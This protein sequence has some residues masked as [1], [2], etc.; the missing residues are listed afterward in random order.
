MGTLVTIRAHH[1]DEALAYRAIAAAF[2]RMHALDAMLS[3]YRPDS[4][5]NQLCR[6]AHHTPFSASPDLFRVLSESLRMARATAGAFSPAIGPL[7]ELWRKA[8]QQH[9]LPSPAALRD[10]RARASWR[11]IRLDPA[12]G[13]VRLPRPGMQLDFGG[14]AKGYAADEA[15]VVLAR[16]G[17][18]RAMVAASGDIAVSVAPGASIPWHVALD[19][20][21]EADAPV[22]R[23][24]HHA[25][26]TS[27]DRHQHV[28]IEGVRYSHIV[29]P[30]TGFGLTQPIAAS[31]IGPSALHTDS[32][33]TA[34]TVLGFD[35]A[36]QF[37]A[38]HPTLHARLVRATPHHGPDIW[39]S[40]GFAA[41]LA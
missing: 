10:A 14:I 40:P 13:L 23:L 27:G 2:R 16:N 20:G 7:V 36:P 6:T 18:N 9:Q 5:L 3:D 29:H 25:V 4:E 35:G 37:L 34:L 28:D 17:V 15:L 12:R 38:A 24:L 19:T 41:F 31:V 1:P 26:S 32:A 39:Q 33:A 30:R 22:A 11:D 21:L 8:R